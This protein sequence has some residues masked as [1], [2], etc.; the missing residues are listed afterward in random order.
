MIPF[1]KLPPQRPFLSL[2]KMI[3][4][5]ICSCATM[6]CA[7]FAS[8]QNL[9]LGAT[10]TDTCSTCPSEQFGP[11]GAITDGNIKTNRNL[12][13]GAPGAFII[14]PAQPISLDKLVLIPNMTPNGQVSFEVQ[15]SNNPAG[16]PGTWTSHGGPL[17]GDWADKHP[18]DVNF[19][20][21]ASG[22]R[23][24]KVIVHKSP[25]WVSFYEIEGYSTPNRWLL[26]LLI[27]PPLLITGG[28]VYRKRVGNRNRP[29]NVPQ[30]D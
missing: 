18:I 22:V 10:V 6:L 25:A 27:L 14:S 7:S 26:F 21:Q 28:L 11:P 19:D 29:K 24:V 5:L 2:G 12:G 13:G 3:I 1:N 15:T 23:A 20:R 30:K 9:L 16:A 17:S 4:W 8:A